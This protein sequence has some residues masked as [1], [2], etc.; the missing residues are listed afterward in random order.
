MAPSTSTFLARLAAKP[1]GHDLFQALRRIEGAHPSQPRLGDA[2][3]PGDEPIRFAQE[4]SLTF[5]PAA[6]AALESSPGTPPRLV[7]RIFGLLG[8]NGP[9]PIHLTE[10]VRERLLHHADPTPQ[11]FLDMLV[12]RFGLLFYRAW[13][14]SQPVVSL[15]RADDNRTARHLGAL[16]GLG[17]PG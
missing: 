8:P 10:Y 13:A 12:H 3:R 1:H 9:L 5:A 14:R 17:E 11:R 7:Q 6:L 4:A 16:A 15:D 2:L